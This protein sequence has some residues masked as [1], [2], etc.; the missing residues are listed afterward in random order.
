MADFVYARRRMVEDQIAARSIRDERVL[1]AMRTVPR[2]HFVDEGLQAQAYGDFPLP[3]GEGQTISQPY[4]VALMT[5]ALELIHTDKVLEVGTGSGYQAAILA[6]LAAQ[7]YSVERIATVASRAR[8]ILD[9]LG[10]ANVVITVGDGT[11]GWPEEGPFN[12]IVVTAGAPEV[13]RPLVDQLTVN[14]RLVV[15]VGDS[16]SQELLKLVKT[17]HGMERIDLGG[18]RFVKLIG[19]HGWGAAE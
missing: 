6:E 9:E 2:H 11:R 19:N 1:R 7:V 15:P 16:Q 10:Y 18:C 4:I 5:E 17:E 8:R 3:I 12:A 13:P 14:G